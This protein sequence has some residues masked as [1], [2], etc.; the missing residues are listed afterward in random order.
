MPGPH[1]PPLQGLVLDWEPR[2]YRYAYVIYVDDTGRPVQEW[3]PRQRLRPVPVI[4][5]QRP[6]NPDYFPGWST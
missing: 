2:L 5:R 1:Q 6:G 3:I 4:E